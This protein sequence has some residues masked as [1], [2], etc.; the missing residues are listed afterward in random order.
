MG[1]IQQAGPHALPVAIVLVISAAVASL[2][3]SLFGRP[4][5]PKNAPPMTPDQWPIIGSLG[6]F[7]RRCK[8]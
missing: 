4:R 7:S 3:I 5:L 1:L 2:F 8:F 6:F